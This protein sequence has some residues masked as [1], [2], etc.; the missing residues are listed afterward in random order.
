MIISEDTQEMLQSRSTALPRHQQKERWGTKNNK[1]NATYETTN[2][3]TKKNCNR[4][5]AL[6]RTEE[7]LVG[8]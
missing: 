8:A 3:Q 6:E 4:G 1:T 7:M 5:T 2:A